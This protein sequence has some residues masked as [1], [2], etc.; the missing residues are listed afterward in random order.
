MIYYQVLLC[1]L[2]PFRLTARALSDKIGGETFGSNEKYLCSLGVRIMLVQWDKM[3]SKFIERQR[4]KRQQRDR[5]VLLLLLLRPTYSVRACLML[6][7]KWTRKQ[8]DKS[9]SE[10]LRFSLTR[11]VR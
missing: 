9:K 3:L 2:C 6:K 4:E 8:S 1:R 5:C 7:I 10:A 11:Y